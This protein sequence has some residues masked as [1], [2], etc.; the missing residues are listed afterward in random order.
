VLADTLVFPNHQVSGRG[1]NVAIFANVWCRL[2]RRFCIGSLLVNDLRTRSC[3]YA[4]HMECLHGLAK[5]ASY[6]QLRLPL[7]QLHWLY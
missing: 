5:H 4:K 3:K 7:E 2:L 6:T 1:G